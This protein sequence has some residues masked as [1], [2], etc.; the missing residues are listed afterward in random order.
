MKKLEIVNAKEQSEA[1]RNEIFRSEE[2]RYD[3]RLHGLLLVSE[4]VSCYDA[5]VMFGEDPRTIE[6]WVKKFNEK[7]FNSLR[8]GKRTGRPSKLTPKQMDEINSDLRKNPSE[9]GY[10]QNLWDGKLLKHHIS[11][12]F[13]I[14]I[15]V[16]TGQMIFHRLEFRRRKP[17]GVIAKGDPDEQDIFKKNSLRI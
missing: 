4:G 14:E 16:R 6:R 9:F 10:E 12:K 15:G 17:R 2:S 5:G 11:E 3:H 1:I 8:E 13:H 7:G